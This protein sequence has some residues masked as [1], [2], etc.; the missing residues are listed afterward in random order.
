LEWFL[1]NLP[2][3]VE[4]FLHLHPIVES[5][6]L[7]AANG[8]GGYL[9]PSSAKNLVLCWRVVR[10]PLAD[11]IAFGKERGKSCIQ[12]RSHHPL[13]HRHAS[14]SKQWLYANVVAVLPRLRIGLSLGLV[15][16]VVF[17]AQVDHVMHD[18]L[19]IVPH[20]TMHMHRS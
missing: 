3:P 1:A 13:L 8:I 12:C 5:L 9:Q 14:R 18:G 16:L 17:S 20:E 11:P 4:E 10:H 7:G 19:A 6:L 2:L 15:A